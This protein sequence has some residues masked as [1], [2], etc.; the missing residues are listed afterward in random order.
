[1]KQMCN[2][3]QE[4]TTNQAMLRIMG[5]KNGL[6]TSNLQCPENEEQL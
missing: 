2:K 4:T 6:Y 1:M 5:E 3:M